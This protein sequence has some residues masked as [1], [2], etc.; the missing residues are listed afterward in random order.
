MNK[1][2]PSDNDPRTKRT[3]P[4][5]AELAPTESSARP[6]NLNALPVGIT[7]REFE[8]IGLIGQGGFGIVYLAYD[9]S[10]RRQVALKEYMPTSLAERGNG[11]AVVVK[12]Q[13]HRETFLVGLRSFVT[14]A[15]LLAKFDHPSLVKV[16]CFWEGNGTA[17]MAMPFYHGITLEERLEL[18]GSPPDEAWLKELLVQLLEAL[19]IIHDSQCLHRDIAPDNILTLAEGRPLLLDFGAARQVIGD[20]TQ[21]L[22]VILKP[23]YA[24]IEQYA[25]DP[26]M[27]QGPWTD[28][29]ALGAVVYYAIMGQAPIPSV[30][31]VI[32]DS[33]IPLSKAAAGRYSADF[34]KAIDLAMAVKPKDR[35]QNVE[36][37]GVLLGFTRQHKDKH[38]WP[39][40]AHTGS[41]LADSKKRS[42]VGYVALFVSVAVVGI[43][44]FVMRNES[45]VA[46]GVPGVTADT[47]S[48]L[49]RATPPMEDKKFDPVKALDDI[50]EGRDRN[51][52]VTVST[53]KAQ[54]RIGK[55]ALQFSIHSA[56]NGY[57]YVLMVGTDRSD[58]S[59]LFP[60]NSDRRNRIKA[61]EQID[62]PPR[63]AQWTMDALGPPGTNHF[64]AIVSQQ[65]F[66]A[67]RKVIDPIAEALALYRAYTGSA[68][69]SAGTVKCSFDTTPSCPAY[70][71]AVFSIEEIEE[72]KIR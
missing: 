46:P 64:I 3:Q 51:Y 1:N 15:Q 44:I 70:G 37:L 23:G 55:D 60:N 31:R 20:R 47:T 67:A 57:V 7:I 50:F 18:M 21:A 48:E 30:S 17:Y 2:P 34:L 69:L 22:T 58:F 65:D 41:G 9:H 4:I 28:I 29:Y 12:S 11:T 62:L 54:A 43:G 19:G 56:N 8:I 33:L 49:P 14:E 42:V 53:K 16:Y 25:N 71:A 5:T 36:E 35:P 68:P 63:G 13:R 72:R 52:A 6:E 40:L 45:V 10:L 61:G 27:K 59:M 39:E 26:G 66:S 38:R 24:P 32:S